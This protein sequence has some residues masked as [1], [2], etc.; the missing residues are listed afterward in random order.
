MLVLVEMQ[1]ALRFLVF[2]PKDAIGRSEL[3]HDQAASPEVANE[4]PKHSVGNARHRGKDGRWGD[5]EIANCYP[6]RYRGACTGEDVRAHIYRIFPILAHLA[7]LLPSPSY[8][9]VA[10]FAS[11][12]YMDEIPRTSLPE[13]SATDAGKWIGR[14]VIAVIVAEAIWGFIVS[15]TNNLLL[16]LL[17][18]TM[19]GDV[20][21]P[22]YL[23]KG[24][25]NVPALFTSVLELCFAGIAAVILNSWVQRKPTVTRSKV[26]RVSPSP[27]QPAV[28]QP[29]LPTVAPAQAAAASV[30]AATIATVPVPAAPSLS[31]SSVPAQAPPA[32]QFWSPPEA[33]QPKASAAPP[34]PTVPAKPAKPKAPKEVYY[35]IVGEPINPTEDE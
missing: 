27:A 3:G 5:L 31:A 21:S 4:T 2:C 34:P 8:A 7:I 22:L 9:A 33:A 30:P 26:V 14:V 1:V 16:P 13:P 32:G 24:D 23:G 12:N 17:A 6:L 29:T 15:I 11:H 20:Q 28:T 35:N 18:R 19:G 25:F 10:Q